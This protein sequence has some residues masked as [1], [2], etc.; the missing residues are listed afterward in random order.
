MLIVGRPTIQN[1][2]WFTIKYRL[3]RR[4]TTATNVDKST[5]IS[6][7][8]VTTSELFMKTRRLTVTCARVMS[9]VNRYKI[10]SNAGDI[11]LDTDDQS[12]DET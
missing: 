8:F 3:T 4:T 7:A 12:V 11:S 9:R 1:W 10:L 6:L 2:T 5:T